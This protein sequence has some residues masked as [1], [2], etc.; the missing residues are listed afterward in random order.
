MNDLSLFWLGTYISIKSGDVKLIYR[1]K[2]SRISY[3]SL[4]TIVLSDGL[5]GVLEMLQME[6]QSFE[7]EHCTFN[8]PSVPTPANCPGHIFC[9]VI[10]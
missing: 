4:L 7:Y 10:Y 3:A 8:I 5:V 9:Y 1:P 2:T 6:W